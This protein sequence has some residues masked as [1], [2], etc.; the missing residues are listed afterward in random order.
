LQSIETLSSDR[1]RFI[2]G[3]LSSHSSSTPTSVPRSLSHPL[4]DASSNQGS[5]SADHQNTTRRWSEAD[6]PSP[7]QLR[8]FAPNPPSTTQSHHLHQSHHHQHHPHHQHTASVVQ[9]GGAPYLH[10]HTLQHTSFASPPS[11]ASSTLPEY[12]PGVCFVAGA[13]PGG[14]QVSN[15]GRRSGSTSSGYPPPPWVPPWS[16][17]PP[18]YGAQKGDQTAPSKESAQGAGGTYRW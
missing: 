4:P 1:N 6:S 18:I 5:F 16:T 13:S 11:S 17:T 9:A 7:G 12:E 8:H 3:T 15:R 14:A 2:S 10:H